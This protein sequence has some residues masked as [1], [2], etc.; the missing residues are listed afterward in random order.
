M[1][2]VM[3]SPGA[4]PPGTS[5]GRY[6][7]VR[8]I[9]VG[10]MAEL[11]LARQTGEQGYEKVVAIKRI[12]PH[13]SADAD[14]VRMFL[15]EARLAARLSHAGIAQVIDFG[16][17]RG[18][19]FIAMEYIHGRSVQELLHSAQRHGGI[20]HE[21]A[22]TVLSEVAIAL[23]YAHASVG[24]DG[25]GLGLVHR[26]VS[27]SNILVSFAGD[28]KLVDFGIAKAT[29][30]TRATRSG[31]IKGKIAYMAPEQIRGEPVDRRADVFALSVVAYELLTGRK[32]F[33]AQ[34]D[35]ALINRVAQVRYVRPSVHDPEFPPVL[36]AIIVR[37]LSAQRQD[38][39][40]S[41]LDFAAA[42]EEAA[43]QLHLVRSRLVVANWM[44]QI[45]GHQPSPAT[46]P[47][48]TV[49][50]ASS[51]GAS[52]LPAATQTLRRRRRIGLPMLAAAVGLGVGIGWGGPVLFADADPPA[53]AGPAQ[54]QRSA[55]SAPQPAI[56]P[57][58]ASPAPEPKPAP[59]PP[60]AEPP[61]EPEPERSD[62]GAQRRKL[63][64]RRHARRK[65]AGPQTGATK[66]AS[67]IFLP[68]TLRGD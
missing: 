17:E 20:P 58:V 34:G 47:L 63:T 8:R 44:D 9:A 55:S 31:G 4:L 46:E 49:C 53:P 16:S 13:L 42:V 32:C 37:G 28:T 24:P 35:F 41:A 39:F 59:T 43:E 61:A 19:H 52:T 36:E 51:E 25:R 65:S 56:E 18:E 15:N 57:R 22:L 7:I 60:Q 33:R 3:E 38:R 14:F 64:K 29:A 48:P 40:E 45:F 27:P 21:V 62:A 12:L 50:S 66:D 5:L 54:V 68:T 30:H 26:D 2:P 6:R 67:K 11:Y 10:G 1:A 23:H